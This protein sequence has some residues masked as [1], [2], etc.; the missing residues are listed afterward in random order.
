[1]FMV[2]S[3][4]YMHVLINLFQK[5]YEK[6]TVVTSIKHVRKLRHW[7]VRH[8]AKPEFSITFLESPFHSLKY[9]I[10]ILI[11]IKIRQKGTT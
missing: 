11:L 6:V 9:W 1:M 2:C 5:P 10:V 7:Q 3:V 4:P 8:L